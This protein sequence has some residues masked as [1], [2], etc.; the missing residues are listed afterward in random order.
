MDSLSNSVY[1]GPV[2]HYPF[3]IGWTINGSDGL[4]QIDGLWFSRLR[5]QHLNLCV[6]IWCLDGLIATVGW[7]DR[8]VVEFLHF[9]VA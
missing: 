6:D 9:R 5:S 3:G 8:S 1:F 4:L 2:G 7:M